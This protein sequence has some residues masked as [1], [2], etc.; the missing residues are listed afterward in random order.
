MILS[1][2]TSQS[3]LSLSLLLH[4]KVINQISVLVKNELSEIIIPTIRDF[5]KNN[6]ITLENISL[7][8][9]GC[10]P[11]SFT[12]IR[13]VISAAKGI[14]LSYEHIKII[15]I[16]S[17]AGVAMS[18]LAEAKKRNIKYIISS[19]D[20]KR[21]DLF[22]QLFK[23]NDFNDNSLP[24]LAVNIIKPVR[25][26]NIQNYILSNQ[27]CIEDV[28]FIGFMSKS[29]KNVIRN[30]KISEQISQNPDSVWTGKLGSYIIRNN[31]N[32]KKSTIAHDILKPI[33]VRH[34]EIN[35]LIK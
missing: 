5:I 14:T 2:E 28:L 26:E 22:L 23:I 17:L 20:S 31:I 1:I 10:G 35:Q 7:L 11:G 13:A 19:I 18:A 8:I 6:F 4:N 16:N 34:A 15:G 30:L 12:G 3:N 27:L 21:E 25:L 29:L 9:V 24:L 32:Y 33:Y